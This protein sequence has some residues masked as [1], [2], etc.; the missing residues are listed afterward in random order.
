[1][2]PLSIHQE[3]LSQKIVDPIL[4]TFFQHKSSKIQTPAAK[5]DLTVSTSDEVISK[6]GLLIYLPSGSFRL[7]NI[8]RRVFFQLDGFGV[9]D[10]ELGIFWFML[11]NG[12]PR[13]I[14][15]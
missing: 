10:N 4:Y 7:K 12:V 2:V 14:R 5:F 8:Y 3:S 9:Y 11:I 1:M 15:I 13:S 6:S